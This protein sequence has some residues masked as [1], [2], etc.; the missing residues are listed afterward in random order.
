VLA[1]KL[2]SLQTAG[3]PGNPT[4]EG[5]VGRKHRQTDIGLGRPTAGETVIGGSDNPQNH[6]LQAGRLFA[7][8][9]PACFIAQ[10]GKL[11]PRVERH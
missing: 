7:S 8:S 5:R 11:R 9:W 6:V 2:L 3:K 10:M 1:T 4:M